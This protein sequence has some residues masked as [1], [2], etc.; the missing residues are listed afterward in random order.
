MSDGDALARRYES[1]QVTIAQDAGIATCS[2]LRMDGA[3][4]GIRISMRSEI[5]LANAP[6]R[7]Y[8]AFFGLCPVHPN[9]PSVNQR[10]T[11][12]IAWLMCC[13]TLLLY[14]DCHAH[15]A[16][17]LVVL[18]VADRG[19]DQCEVLEVVYLNGGPSNSPCWRAALGLDSRWERPPKL[20][21][22]LGTWL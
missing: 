14:R 4:G 15:F 9:C 13:A 6:D 21:G 19:R 22:D 3:S 11:A 17:N 2:W 18:G 20:H 16:E 8:D 1:P 10:P 7:P 5:Q 12:P